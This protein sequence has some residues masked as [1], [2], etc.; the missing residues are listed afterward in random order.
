[1]YDIKVSPPREAR[2]GVGGGVLRREALTSRAQ[3]LRRMPTEE[4]KRLWHILRARSM[5]VKFR[6]Q[7]VI[8]RFIVDFACF[9]KKLIIEVDGGQHCQNMKDILRDQWLKS[10]GFEV[11]RFWNNDILGNLDGVF[12]MIEA[13]LKAPSPDPPHASRGRES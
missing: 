12:E 8:G 7:A 2:E 6:R 4:E 5:G 9:E 11:M 3:E 13:R 1:M 10:Q